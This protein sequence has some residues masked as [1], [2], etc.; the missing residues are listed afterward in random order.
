MWC[1]PWC[2]KSC[3]AKPD[4]DLATRPCMLAQQ[5]RPLDFDPCL[6]M[7]SPIRLP[8]LLHRGTHCGA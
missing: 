8:L 7:A 2:A 4:A 1:A 5:D 6:P 3:T